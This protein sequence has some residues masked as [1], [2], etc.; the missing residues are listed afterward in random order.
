MAKMLEQVG[1]VQIEL[2]DAWLD[3]TI[4][5]RAGDQNVPRE[6]TAT[7]ASTGIFTI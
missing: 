2:M 3:P 5:D 7:R 1:K 6:R 4:V